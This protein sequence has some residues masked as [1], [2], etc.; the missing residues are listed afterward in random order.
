M[1]VDVKFY[2]TSLLR[3][4]VVAHCMV[5]CKYVHVAIV[6]LVFTIGEK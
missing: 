1:S 4:S 6:V 2:N 3:M 5:V